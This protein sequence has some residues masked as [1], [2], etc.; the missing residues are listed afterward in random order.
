MRRPIT[1]IIFSVIFCCLINIVFLTTLM[2]INRFLTGLIVFFIVI[3]SVLA[4]VYI[5][6]KFLK[7]HF[8]K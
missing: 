7:K 6:E 5:S 1:I 3:L 2:K 8:K 4:T